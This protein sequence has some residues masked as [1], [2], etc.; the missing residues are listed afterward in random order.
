M[1]QRLLSNWLESFLEF[2]ENSESPRSYRLW[3]GIGAVSAA[4]R[5]RVFMQRGHSTIY[6]NQYI[7]LIGR[8]GRTRKGEPIMVAK[9]LCSAVGLSLLPEEITRESLSKT[10]GES[11]AD[12]TS[13][14]DTLF[15]CAIAGFLEELAVFTGEQNRTFL[16]SLTNWYDSRDDWGRKTKNKGA[17]TVMGVCLT[18]V[19]SSAPDWLPMILPNEAIGGGFTSRVM[20]IVEEEKGQILADPPPASIELRSKLLHDLEAMM[21][22]VGEYTFADKAAKKFYDDWYVTGEKAIQAGK[23]V[24]DDTIFDGYVSRRATHLRKISMA[25][26]A[27]QRNELVITEADMHTALSWMEAAESKMPRAFGGIGRARYAGEVDQIM[28]MLRQ[29]SPLPRSL[30]MSRLRRSIDSA[31]LDQVIKTLEQMRAIKCTLRED[32]EMMLAL[33]LTEISDQS[34]SSK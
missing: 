22:I 20:F 28:Q 6:P 10:L 8:S 9:S 31:G 30:I 26:A 7:I 18:L 25:V 33:P 23:P 1:P 13:G 32:R 3:A 24:L 14:S 27:S 4:L 12:F 29:R 19:A 5:R 34:T 16:A 2:T 11:V 15:E 17:D 21:A